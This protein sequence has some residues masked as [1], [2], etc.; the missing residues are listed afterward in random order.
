VLPA[1]V[2]KWL[3]DHGT[4]DGSLVRLT[5][6]DDLPVLLGFR[7][8]LSFPLLFTA[9]RLYA[10][11][12]ETQTSR[13]VPHWFSDG[14]IGSNF[15]VHFF[16]TW[17][18]GRPTFALS[19]APFPRDQAG[20]LL[21]DESDIGLPLGP[22]DQRFARWVRIDG[23]GG[24]MGQMLETM[25][26]WRD[27]VQS[28]LPGFRDRVYEAR[29]DKEAG[30]GGLNLGMD[31]ATV[32]R[33]QDRGSR[34]GGAIL[35]TFDRDQH[36]FTRYLMTM[37]QQE[38][39]LLGSEDPGS[40]RRRPGLRTAFAQL[41]KRFAA[42]SVGAGELFGRE[43]TWL[44]PAGAATSALL[45]LAETWKKFGSFGGDEPRPQPVIRIVPDV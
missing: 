34:V 31:R 37:Q 16:D 13:F 20:L 21:A 14:G 22:N 24:F 25:Q 15:P 40:G 38:M 43:S 44:P 8:S 41:E 28:E 10:P 17:L 18:P 30:E 19:F 29:L 36:V 26:N 39:G 42:G 12:M 6:E 11:L 33:L 32:E 2:L 5:P 1:A 27:T 9:L 7:L 23:M 35:E 45:D 3:A 4:R